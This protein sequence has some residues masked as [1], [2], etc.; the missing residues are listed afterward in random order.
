M[1]YGIEDS[2][3]QECR[4]LLNE[5]ASMVDAFVELLNKGGG[6]EKEVPFSFNE[7]KFYILGVEPVEI[8]DNYID[9]SLNALFEE[10]RA[11]GLLYDFLEFSWNLSSGEQARMDLFSRI[12]EYYEDKF[13]YIEKNELHNLLILL[14][15][16]DMLLHPEW[17]RNY[18]DNLK[19]FLENLFENVPIHIQVIISTH[20][21]IMLSDIPKQN[22]LFLGRRDGRITEVKGSQTFS[23]NI[24]DLYRNA[25]FIEESGIGTFAEKKLKNILHEI[26]EKDNDEE[27]RIQKY[28][29]CIGDDFIRGKIML[30]YKKKFGVM[31]E[32]NKRIAELE[33]ELAELKKEQKND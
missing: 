32:K 31:D 26:R 7:F 29:S 6:R 3:I 1:S 22:I 18:V 13:K 8:D 16:A 19:E 33:K 5:S 9:I 10:Y 12:Y 11:I 23:S 17:Q 4:S 27:G 20:S 21:P 15:E 28:I 30:E 14:D 24:F 25:F 2:H